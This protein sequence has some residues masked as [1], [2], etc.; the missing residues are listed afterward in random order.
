M[1]VLTGADCVD[2]MIWSWSA[3]SPGTRVRS[4]GRDARASPERG[5][6]APYAYADL[7]LVELGSRQPRSLAGAFRTPVP[8]GGC[9]GFDGWPVTV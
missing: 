3:S 5:S 4:G 7:M 1:A 8:L 6:T 2:E 9:T